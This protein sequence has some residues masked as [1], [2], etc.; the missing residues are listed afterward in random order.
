MDKDVEPAQALSRRV[1]EP[2]IGICVSDV[3]GVP[4]RVDALGTQTGDGLVDIHRRSRAN[5]Y[6]DPFS[7]QRPGDAQ[8][9]TLAG[10]RYDG[11]PAFQLQI[12]SGSPVRFPPA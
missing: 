9:D 3:D 8:P 1:E 6:I 12:H 10:T 2:D 7:G 5:R 11:F 4:Q